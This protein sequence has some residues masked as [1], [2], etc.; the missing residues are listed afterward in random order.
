MVEFARLEKHSQ[1]MFPHPLGLVCCDQGLSLS[2]PGAA[3]VG[4]SGN[5]MGGG[6]SSNG[7]LVLSLVGNPTFSETNLVRYSDWFVTSEFVIGNDERKNAALQTTFGHGSPFVY[8]KTQGD[9]PS[10]HFAEKPL[11]WSDPK[12]AVL[13]V[14]VRGNHYGIFGAQESRWQFIEETRLENTT[15]SDYYSIALLPD[16]R[17]KTLELFAKYAHNHVVDSQVEYKIVDGQVI[18][19]YH[20]ATKAME[21]SEGGNPICTVSTSMEVQHVQTT[22]P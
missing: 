5:I 13:G 18:S 3:I 12:Q 16:N 8:C 20:F 19:H 17:P 7:D 11:V 9:R 2:Y 15:Q 22:R 6:V 1:N 21:A 10:I 4:S 14:T